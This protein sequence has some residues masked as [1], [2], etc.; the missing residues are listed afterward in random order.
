MPVSAFTEVAR[1]TEAWEDLHYSTT[2]DT[3][4]CN[5]ILDGTLQSLH[6]VQELLQMGEN[7]Y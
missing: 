5:F 4:S 3:W 1:Y 6:T 2:Q 7:S